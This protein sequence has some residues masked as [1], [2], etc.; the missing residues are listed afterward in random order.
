MIPELHETEYEGITLLGKVGN[1]FPV[2]LAAKQ[3][4]NHE[5]V[6]VV[7]IILLLCKDYAF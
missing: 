2:H 6:T 4:R 3:P 1:Y 5:S 7:R